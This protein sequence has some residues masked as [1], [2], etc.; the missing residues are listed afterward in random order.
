MFINGAGE[1]DRK[2]GDEPN[3]ALVANGVVERGL[4]D[5]DYFT[6]IIGRCPQPH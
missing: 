6:R 4:I 1:L 2:H 5:R 3:F